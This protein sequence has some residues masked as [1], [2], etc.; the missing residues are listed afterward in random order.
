[1]EQRFT[2]QF[3]VHASEQGMVLREFLMQKKISRTA[4]TDIKY[5][6]GA[7]TV[8]GQPET[9]RYILKQADIVTVLFPPEQS[10]ERMTGEPL[11]LS[12]VYEDAFLLIVEKPAGMSTIPSREHPNGTLANAILFHYEQSGQQNAVHFVTR[13]D[14]DTSGLVLVAKHRYIH[15]L[16]SLA[17]QAQCIK[18]EYLALIEGTLTPPEGNIR[19]PIARV[20]DS[21][22]KREVRADGQPAHTYYQTTYTLQ[23]DGKVYSFVRLQLLT[24]RTHQIR[25]HLSWL[26][27]PLLGDALYG[28][29][30]TLLH[31]QAL[32]C[33][34]LQFEHPITNQ[35]LQFESTWPTDLQLMNA[36]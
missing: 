5:H 35:L 15:H 18:K 8:N 7:L 29:D 19:Q 28:G 21:I 11:P 4:L 6:G 32:H 16:L 31:R 17:Q 27:H 23:Q 25:V 24:G 36:K 10:S 26:G 9:V 34:R 3:T 33:I 14:Y 20:N 12:I 1:M 13:L 30:C 2:L 22:I